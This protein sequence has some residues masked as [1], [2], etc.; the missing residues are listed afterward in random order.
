MDSEVID[1]RDANR[2]ELRVEGRLAVATY[3]REP[4]RITLT[5][6]IVPKALEGRGIASRLI[7][8]AL[9]AARAEGLKV[10]P[11]CPFVRAYI[12]RHPEMKDLLA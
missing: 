1:N 12:E 5:H 9:E 2:F 11:Q 6:T 4:D 3:E 8:A 10:V 7:R